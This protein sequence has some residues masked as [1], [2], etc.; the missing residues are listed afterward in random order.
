MKMFIIASRERH[1]ITAKKK[2]NR[3]CFPSRFDH[4]ITKTTIILRYS[5]HHLTKNNENHISR[6]F[7]QKLL[8]HFQM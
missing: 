4:F 6:A 5:A 7:Q 1:V 3:L 8:T 2:W